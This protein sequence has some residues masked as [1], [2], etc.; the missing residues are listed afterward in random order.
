[1]HAAGVLDGLHGLIVAVG[2]GS[3]AISLLALMWV[4]A[5]LTPFLNAGPS[6]A[7]L[8]PVAKALNVTFPGSAVWWAL[9]LGVL[10]GSSATLSG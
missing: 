1:M 2:K 10:A 4:A 9:S 3:P 6:T 7:F 5:L 8:V